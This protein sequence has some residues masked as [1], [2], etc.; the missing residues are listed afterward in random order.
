MEWP[1][2]SAG[3]LRRFYAL[4]FAGSDQGNGPVYGRGQVWLGPG[5]G[6]D[7]PADTF[8]LAGHNRQAIAIVPSL[9]LV[10]LRMGSTPED[11]G[12]SVARLLHSIVVAGF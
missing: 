10:I 3:R 2:A 1:T 4:A 5:L 12:Y 7:L 9:K 11:I 6:F 8:V